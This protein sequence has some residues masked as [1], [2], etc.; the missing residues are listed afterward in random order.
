MPSKV[1]HV[2][3]LCVALPQAVW[4][5]L[6]GRFGG[7]PPTTRLFECVTCRAEAT[8]LARQKKFELDEFKALHAEF[9]ETENPSS[10]Y[11]LSS[12]WFRQWEAFVTG[13]QRDPPSAIDNKS[14]VSMRP[15][16]VQVRVAYP[17]IIT[18][19]L[20]QQ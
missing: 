1:G 3:D 4:E 20:C 5:L 15:G 14:I 7:G 8:A 10:I 13:R 12:S 6:H 11:C 19:A 17:Y 2:Y 18:N 9:Q 16:G